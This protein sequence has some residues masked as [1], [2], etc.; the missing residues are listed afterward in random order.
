M[1]YFY[2]IQNLVTGRNIAIFSSRGE[3]GSYCNYRSVNDN[4]YIFAVYDTDSKKYLE[5]YYQGKMMDYET[6]ENTL[7]DIL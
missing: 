2:T 7:Y 4:R 6:A 3:A 5:C 1:N